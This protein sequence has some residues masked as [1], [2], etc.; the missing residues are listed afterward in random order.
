[1]QTK[2]GCALGRLQQIKTNWVEEAETYQFRQLALEE[3]D[4]EWLIEQVEKVEQLTAET[5]QLQKRGDEAIQ[6]AG[7]LWVK[8]YHAKEA[9]K[10]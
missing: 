2:G 5:K 3:K 9:L 7:R 10:D 8:I 6:E 4:I 1:L